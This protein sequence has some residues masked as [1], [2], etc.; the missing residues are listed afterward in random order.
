MTIKKRTDGHY[1]VDIYARGRSGK[2]FR[3][4]FDRKQEAVLFE[5]YVMANA[6]KKSGWARVLIAEP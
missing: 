3:R 2:R 6:E 5:R 4:I 1:E